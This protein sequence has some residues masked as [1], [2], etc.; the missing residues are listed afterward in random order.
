MDDV[1]FPPIGRRSLLVLLLLLAGC[2][3]RG[4]LRRPEAEEETRP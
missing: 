1:S 4:T 3:K 2:G